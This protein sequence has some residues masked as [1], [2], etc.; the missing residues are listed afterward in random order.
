VRSPLEPDQ[1]VRVI[2]EIDMKVGSTD[3]IEQIYALGNAG[4]KLVHVPNSKLPQ[5]LPREKG[6]TY[7]QINREQQQSEWQ[8]VERSLV[9]AIRFNETKIVGNIDRQELVNLRLTTDMG[10]RFTLFLLGAGAG[11]SSPRS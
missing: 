4:L 1:C 7:F 3:R 8:H 2:D 6:L 5:A 11:T 9:L 10:F